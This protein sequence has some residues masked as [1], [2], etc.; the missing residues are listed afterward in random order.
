MPLAKATELATAYGFGVGW[1]YESLRLLEAQGRV[2]SAS[3]SAVGR[4]AQRWWPA[5][6]G[7]HRH[8]PET[9][10]RLLDNVV[11]VHWFYFMLPYI[12]DAVPGRQLLEFAWYRQRVFEAAAR[13]NDGWVAF[14]WTGYWQNQSKLRRRF[15]GL[16]ESMQAGGSEAR[17]WPSLLCF[18]AAD[19]WQ[20]QL[21]M[22]VAREF[23]MGDRT[24]VCTVDDRLLF[25]EMDFGPGRGWL[26]PPVGGQEL[27]GGVVERAASKS[28]AAVPDGHFLARLAQVVEQWPGCNVR[29]L[30]ELMRVSWGR[31]KAGLVKLE[32]LGMI[33]GGGKGYR[34]S[35]RWYAAAARRDRVRSGLPA[36]MFSEKNLDELYLGRIARH[37]KGVLRVVQAFAKDG[38]AYAPGWRCVDSMGRDGKIAPDA[39]VWIEQ[40][41]FGPGWHYVKYE[42]RAHQKAHIEAK[43]RGYQSALRADGY[44]L[45]TVCNRKVEDM[46]QVVGQ[47]LDM[48][49]TTVAEA[50]KGPLVGTNGTVWRYFGQ[51][52]GVLSGRVAEERI[53]A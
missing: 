1:T 38:C 45:L 35:R 4:P 48:L 43:L 15:E 9:V 16:S 26:L 8:Q 41:P 3:L 27:D 25:G 5:G 17:S 22:D 37:E 53:E 14:F 46:F 24:C 33:V 40:G 19:R 12:T 50:R 28:L 42:L 30:S 2:R 29:A 10:A 20:G 34:A 39:V 49:T 36:K 32:G 7:D 18:V 23:G 44:P 21:V 6:P 52:V 11:A 13:F 51:P 47:G 31:V